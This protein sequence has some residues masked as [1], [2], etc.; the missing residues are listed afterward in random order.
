MGVAFYH[1]VLLVAHLL[2][3]GNWHGILRQLQKLTMYSMPFHDTC[4]MYVHVHACKFVH[5]N[6]GM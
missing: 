3:T 4:T 5:V 2:Y 1:I 6:L